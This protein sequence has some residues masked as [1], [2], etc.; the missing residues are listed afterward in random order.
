LRRVLHLIPM[1]NFGGASRAAI[2][3]AAACAA[4]SEQHVIASIRPSPGGMTADAQARGIEV[5]DAPPAPELMQAIRAA[6][7]T[8]VHL[9]NSPEL[10]EVLE[11]ELPPCR[12]L[13]WTHVAGHSPTQVLPPEIFR[14]VNETVATSRRAARWVRRSHSGHA[15]IVIPAVG[16][17]G[18]LEGV[19]R[20]SRRGFNVGYMGTVAFSRMHRDFVRMS[21]AAEVDDAQFIV[22]GDGT[23]GATLRREAG[24][25][26]ASERFD[27]RG[28]IRQIRTA[29]SEFDLFGFPMRPDTSVSS[30]LSLKEAMYAGVPPLVLAGTGCGELVADGQTGVIVPDPA[31]YARAIERLHGD[32][33]ERERLARN[34]RTH[35]ADTWTPSKWAPVWRECFERVMSR[36]AQ[37]GPVLEGPDPDLPEG[38][39]RF[40]RGLG[41]QGRDFE[42]SLRGS[43][44]EAQAAEER[45]A[46]CDPLIAYEDNGLFDLRR[47]YP[48]DPALAL[49]TGLFMKGQGRPAL[50]AGELARAR[51]LG[52]DPSRLARHTSLTGAA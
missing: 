30:D 22:C 48:E 23:A 52:C 37:A 42:L 46:E 44:T 32:P 47:R 3:T 12:L 6:D 1:L 5:L 38:A 49:W 4:E 16:G 15:P 26:G 31:A 11:S 20:S 50:A 29:L 7:V 24:E 36:P 28:Q 41:E 8:L 45:I 34:A 17:W 9:W 2:A 43:A 19:V 14:R 33:E 10:H 21:L 13:V 40:L 27:F 25:L 35:A 39:A 18:R 51:R